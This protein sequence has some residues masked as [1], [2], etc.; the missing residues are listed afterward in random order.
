MRKELPKVRWGDADPLLRELRIVKTP[1]EVAYIET[2]CQ[3][4]DRGIIHA[5]NHLEGTVEN[6]GYT[7]AEFTERT[8]VHTFEDGASGVGHMSTTLGPDACLFY[9]PSRGVFCQDI[10]FKCDFTSHYMG[11]WAN[12]GRMAYTG[13]PPTE[14]VQAYEENMTLKQEAL[15]AL[16][17][18][19]TCSEVFEKVKSKADEAGIPFLADYGIGHG[20]G[21][22]HYEPPYLEPGDE[23]KLKAGMV[24]A[25]DVRTWGPGR[26]VIHSKDVYVVEGGGTRLLSWY[27]DWDR[28]YEV[29]GF[30]ATH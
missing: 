10:P 3:Y 21:V 15:N 5:L 12:L 7:V 30:R 13:K 16:E 27:R 9:S 2:A 6:P 19:V 8:R 17:P 23:T 29:T 24:V 22:S 11:Y 28:F 18:G 26:E 1:E 25:V 20:V 4:L 14:Y